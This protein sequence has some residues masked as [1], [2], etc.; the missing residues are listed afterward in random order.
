MENGA[1][2]A[3]AYNRRIF[4]EQGLNA[5]QPPKRVDEVMRA[6]ERLT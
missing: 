1:R 6:H 5:G 2:G 3:L 4:T